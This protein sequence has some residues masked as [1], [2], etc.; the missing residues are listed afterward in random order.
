MVLFWVTKTVAAPVRY[1][2]PLSPNNVIY[3]PNIET[4]V[5][6]RPENGNSSRSGISEGHSTR[7]G[8]TISE[9]A[10]R[11][12]LESKRSPL[13]ELSSRIL[14]SEYWSSIIA[15]CTIEEYSCS[16]NP[17]GSNNLWGIMCSGRICRYD[18]LAAGIDAIDRFL[19]RAEAKGRTTIES[20]RS[21]YC[22]SDSEP[23]H[24]CRNWESVVL[25]TKAAV[26]AL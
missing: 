5:G 7:S 21:W 4:P 13:A 6:I 3:K 25:R 2:N 26:E 20:F 11:L 19:E 14:E 22:Y 17:Y 15:I 12:Y 23:G 24:V 1:S 18:S 10:I 16:V 9:E 8:T